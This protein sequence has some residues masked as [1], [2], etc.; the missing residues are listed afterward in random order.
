MCSQPTINIVQCLQLMLCCCIF[1]SSLSI[2]H[3]HKKNNIIR[4][5]VAPSLLKKISK[6][7]L[8]Q[9]SKIEQSV[10]ICHTITRDCSDF[11]DAKIPLKPDKSSLKSGLI[12]FVG[13]VLPLKTQQDGSFESK[14]RWRLNIQFPNISSSCLNNY[15]GL[16]AQVFVLGILNAG[17]H[18]LWTV[19]VLEIFWFAVCSGKCVLVRPLQ[20][21]STLSW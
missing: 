13:S 5:R 10:Y 7:G 4:R 14:R 21:N 3:C 17:R 9:G 1:L 6:R 2:S 11:C 12:L 16:L 20:C 15:A 18:L 8:E 19:M